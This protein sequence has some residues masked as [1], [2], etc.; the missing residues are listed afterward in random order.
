[1]LTQ[2]G[3]RTSHSQLTATAG[4]M[5]NKSILCR[6]LGHGGSPT[7]KQEKHYVASETEVHTWRPRS[8]AGARA[9]PVQSGR[10]ASCERQ[11]YY[12]TVPGRAGRIN[13]RCVLFL[14]RGA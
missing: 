5:K 10:Y 11:P 6:W 13:G 1:M 9:V 12:P 3:R 4:T 2:R 14:G 8:P 7:K